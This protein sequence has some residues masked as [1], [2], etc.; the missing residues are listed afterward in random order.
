MRNMTEAELLACQGM[1]EGDIRPLANVLDIEGGELHPVL[2][3]WLL[4]LI[5]GRVDETDYRL[6]V[7][8]HPDLK[9]ASDGPRA[10]R[11]ASLE[12]INM[13][14]AMARNG[15]FEE[16]QWEAAVTATQSET[17]KGRSTIADH[18]S[19]KKRFLE[20]SRAHGILKL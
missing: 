5:C 11:L 20:F 2:Q 7:V 15:A 9:R 8:R 13:A 4:K 1:V 18:W 16:G 3:M 19:S 17:G 12:K 14:L 10:K 6:A